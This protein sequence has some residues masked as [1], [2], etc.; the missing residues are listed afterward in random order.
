MLMAKSLGRPPRDIAADLVNEVSAELGDSVERIEVAGPGFINLFLADSW[1]RGVVGD[2]TAEG[3]APVPP[4]PATEKIL[5][6]FVSALSLI[7]I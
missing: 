6:E 1:Y 7:H 2:L 5:I 3:S 4:L